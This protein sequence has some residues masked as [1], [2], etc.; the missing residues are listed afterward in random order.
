M[1]LVWLVIYFIIKNIKKTCYL[2]KPFRSLYLKATIH[3]HK[4]IQRRT[5]SLNTALLKMFSLI[6]TNRAALQLFSS[7][8][9]YT[10]TSPTIYWFQSL[11]L[12]QKHKGSISE[13]LYATGNPLQCTGVDLSS[14][15]SLLL[16]YWVGFIAFSVH[17]FVCLWVKASIN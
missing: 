13:L 1:K 5:A 3:W 6:E 7:G 15:K 9:G 4:L 17:W 12:G 10:A 11:P 8:G 14:Y 2:F 16:V